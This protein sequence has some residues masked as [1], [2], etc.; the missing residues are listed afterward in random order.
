M[1]TARDLCNPYAPNRYAHTSGGQHLAIV[2]S[3]THTF[4]TREE[5]E[6]MVIAANKWDRAREDRVVAALELE[7]D[8]GACDYD[9]VARDCGEPV[10]YV[11]KCA[12]IDG[13]F[14]RADV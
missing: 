11:A 12:R 2:G 4:T 1:N 13:R 9:A 8:F 3:R 5:A 7:P 6:S 10:E 14:Y